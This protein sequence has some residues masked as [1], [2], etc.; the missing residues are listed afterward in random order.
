VSNNLQNNR[1]LNFTPVESSTHTVSRGAGAAG[2][3]DTDCSA[4]VGTDPNK[5]WLV[6][7]QHAANTGVVG[8]RATGETVDCSVAYSLINTCISLLTRCSS[9]GHIDLYRNAVVFNYIFV[10]YFS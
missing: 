2:F 6:T 5:I 9:T 1:I 4:I 8:A 10:G 7:V 3:V